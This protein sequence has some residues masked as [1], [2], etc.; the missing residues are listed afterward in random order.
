MGVVMSV[1]PV[2]FATLQRMNEVSQIKQNEISKPM[3]DQVNIKNQFTKEINSK[4]EQVGKKDDLDNGQKKFDA[5]EKG[6]NNY[7]G[8][9]ASKHD[10]E[11][12]TSEGRVFVKGQKGF[13]IKI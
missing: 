8:S 1:R 9:N 10:G 4:S 6:S 5:K 11:E 3:I 12:D 7:F 13:D 2:D